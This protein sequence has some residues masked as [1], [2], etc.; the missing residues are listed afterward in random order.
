M[1]T[2]AQYKERVRAVLE[3]LNDSDGVVRTVKTARGIE[4]T[5]KTWMPRIIISRKDYNKELQH[6]Q[7]LGTPV[8]PSLVEI[9]HKERE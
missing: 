1:L 3:H 8:M 4:V 9:D 7:R 5:M 6:W 2:A